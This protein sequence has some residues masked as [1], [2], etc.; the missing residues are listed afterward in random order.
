MSRLVTLA[1]AHDFA[2]TLERLTTALKTFAEYT[3]APG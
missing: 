3:V 1:S 2:T